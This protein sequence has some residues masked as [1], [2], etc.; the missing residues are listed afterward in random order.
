MQAGESVVVA[1]GGVIVVAVFLT[2]GLAS[3]TASAA[4]AAWVVLNC[5]LLFYIVQLADAASK[6]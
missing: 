1:V 6:S 2:A 3:L 5:L 4:E